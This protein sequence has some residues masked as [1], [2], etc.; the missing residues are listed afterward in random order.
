MASVT[1]FPGG[2]LLIDYVSGESDPA[3]TQAIVRHWTTLS[4][5]ALMAHERIAMQVLS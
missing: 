1:E 3:T 5:T 4:D 2:L